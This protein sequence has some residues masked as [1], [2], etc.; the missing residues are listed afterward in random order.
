MTAAPTLI[1]AQ[2]SVGWTERTS[3]T[4]S[5][6]CNWTPESGMCARSWRMLRRSISAH[7]REVG[8]GGQQRQREDMDA[9]GLDESIACVAQDAGEWEQEGDDG[10]RI[11]AVL[12]AVA[13]R[14]YGR[15]LTAHLDGLGLLNERFSAAHAIWLDREDR[16]NVRWELFPVTI[17]VHDLDFAEYLPLLDEQG[18]TGPFRLGWSMDYPSPQNYLEPLYSTAALPPNGSNTKLPVGI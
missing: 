8:V 18:V 4:D 7:R 14:R 13:L 9:E 3:C 12:D 1:A 5:L 11:Q 2:S 16:L 17:L 6:P 15:S 10:A